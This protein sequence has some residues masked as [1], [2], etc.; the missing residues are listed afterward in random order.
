MMCRSSVQDRG[1]RL[2]SAG[3]TNTEP[4]LYL[5]NTEL[6]LNQPILPTT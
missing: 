3:F 4:Q 6:I 5:L 2:Q 1:H